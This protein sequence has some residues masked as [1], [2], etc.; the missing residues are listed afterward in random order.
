MQFWSAASV[1]LAGPHPL[2]ADS[3]VKS[4]LKA[5]RRHLGSIRRLADFVIDTSKFN[6]HELR[7]LITERFRATVLAEEAC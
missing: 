3:P 1:K 2:G 7:S 4:A 5:E 6:V